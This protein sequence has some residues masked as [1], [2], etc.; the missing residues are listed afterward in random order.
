MQLPKQLIQYVLYCRL[1]QVT[2]IGHM[3]ERTMPR[4]WVLPL[5][6]KVLSWSLL[7]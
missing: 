7:P 1:D 4:S 2:G 3:G 5:A 6:A